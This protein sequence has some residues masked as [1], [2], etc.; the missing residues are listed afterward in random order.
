MTGRIGQS[1]HVLIT[2]PEPA[3]SRTAQRLRD[4]GFE[5]SVAPLTELL[6]LAP[7]IALSERCRVIATSANAFMADPPDGFPADLIHDF[8]CV[9]EQ[10]ARASVAWGLPQPSIVAPDAET[11]IARA[12]EAGI[13][14]KRWPVVYFAGRYRSLTLEE[15]LS[16]MAAVYEV[17]ETYE[18]R[19]VPDP[20]Q[21]VDLGTIHAV[22]LMSP[23]AAEQFSAA[24]DEGEQMKSV[25][26]S[27]AARDRLSERLRRL[28]VVAAEPSFDS[29][30]RCLM[31]FSEPSGQ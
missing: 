16:R 27:D 26:I 9:G 20:F 25:C 30:L 6:P 24:L 18:A 22:L 21:A 10:T 2:R 23:R 1:F 15:E 14:L 19:A 29:M 4:L 31:A 12:S 3:A 17:Y 13:D 11:L 8:I 5:T 28:A 7:R